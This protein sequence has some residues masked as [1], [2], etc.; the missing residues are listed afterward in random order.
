VKDNLLSF[1]KIIDKI[2][3]PVTLPEEVKGKLVIYG[4]ERLRDAY[5]LT[6]N[7]KAVK[8]FIKKV[9]GAVKRAEKN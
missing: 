3:A 6:D 1:Y 2:T 5:L 7:I 9:D 4:F 8:D